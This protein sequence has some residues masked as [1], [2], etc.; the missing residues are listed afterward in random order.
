MTSWNMVGHSLLDKK[1]EN[2]YKS[3][4]SRRSN[5][6][7]AALGSFNS[8]TSINIFWIAKNIVCEVIQWLEQHFR[9]FIALKFH[10]HRYRV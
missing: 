9:L 1:I 5:L 2:A 3:Y 6:L 8:M 4:K 10:N 7:K